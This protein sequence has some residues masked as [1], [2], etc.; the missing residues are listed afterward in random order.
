MTQVSGFA[1]TLSE[2]LEPNDLN[3]AKD[4]GGDLAVHA[5]QLLAPLFQLVHPAEF[6]TDEPRIIERPALCAASKYS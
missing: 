6:D 2:H 3:L 5:S 4:R 1:T